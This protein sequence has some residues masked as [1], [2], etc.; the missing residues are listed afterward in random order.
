[1]L[2]VVAG[3]LSGCGAQAHRRPPLCVQSARAVLAA[4][5]GV[6]VSAVSQAVSTG[7]NDMPQCVLTVR[8][9]GSRPVQ[10]TVNLDNGPQPYF[11]LER[12]AV[13]ATQQFST[14]R[15]YT[16]PQQISGLGL[17]A[18]WFPDSD[19]LE[20]TDGSRLIT[21]TIGWPGSKGTQRRALAVVIARP[22]IGRLHHNPAAGY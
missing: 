17:D 6:Q 2:I 16:A 15:L 20:T 7:S 10:V 3:A 1:M 8:R 14:V 12:T 5:L 9:P 13:E 19:Y 22:F 11:R 18:D 21:V 4:H